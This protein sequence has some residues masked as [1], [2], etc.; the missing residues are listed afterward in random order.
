MVSVSY[1]NFSLVCY[2][3]FFGR[4]VCQVADAVIEALGVQVLLE[5]N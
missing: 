3:S 5:V 2:S 1:P 4:N